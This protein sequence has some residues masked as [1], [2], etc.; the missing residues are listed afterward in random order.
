MANGKNINIKFPFSDSPKGYYVDLT[1]DTA[2]AIKS[3]LM[4]LILTRKGERYYNPSYGTNLL[5]FIFEPNDT[6]THA[7]VS[8]DIK[9]T[10]K[11]YIPNLQIN[12]VDVKESTESEFTVIV[13]IDYTVTEGIL[14]ES[15]F[16]LINI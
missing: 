5:K 12:N 2:S 10:V 8:Q 1:A 15:D 7:T 14:E 4:L 3:D 6:L 11:K 9:D 13:R 16:V